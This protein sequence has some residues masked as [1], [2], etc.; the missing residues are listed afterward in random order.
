MSKMAACPVSRMFRIFM[1]MMMPMAL[2]ACM[3]QASCFYV[4]NK[5]ND[6]LS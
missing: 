1:G 3:P 4:R 5:E 2:C 6:R